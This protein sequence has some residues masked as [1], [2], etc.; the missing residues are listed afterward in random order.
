MTGIAQILWPWPHTLKP[1][2]TLRTLCGQA[3][4]KIFAGCAHP[5][6]RVVQVVD[7]RWPI[8]GAPCLQIRVGRFDSGPR[9]QGSVC[10]STKSPTC[11]GFF[12]PATVCIAEMGWSGACL[13]AVTA[14]GQCCA[15]RLQ[16]H[17]M[18]YFGRSLGVT[19]PINFLIG[20]PVYT[21]RPELHDQRVFLCKKENCP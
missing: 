21:A 18:L 13:H 6:S 8:G 3:A 10:R 15:T 17:P 19:C 12:V 2:N 5:D 14:R 11:S 20:I 4:A 7:A 16:P 1:L 9:L